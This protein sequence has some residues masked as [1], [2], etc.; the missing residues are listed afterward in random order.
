MPLVMQSR[1]PD[2][3]L[4]ATKMDIGTDVNF[5]NL[6]RV[7]FNYLE[8]LPNVTLHL[9]HELRDLEKLEN[10]QWRLKVKDELNDLKKY[11]DTD[12]VFLGAGGGSLPLLDKS[13]IEEAKGY[14]GFPVSGEWLVCN[15]PEVIEQHAAKV[16]GK[17]SV[18]APPMS[19]PHLDTR[20][21]DGKKELLF[22]P[23]A[24]FSTKFL[25]H[26][27]YFDLPMSIEFD[28]VIPML[29]AG[30]DNI[31]LTKYLILQVSMS[32]E[33]KVEA[34]KEYY[35][36]AKL[37]DWDIKIAGQRVQVIKDDPEKGGVLEFGTELVCS[38]DGSLAALLGASP[39][40]ST[41]VKAML[42]V[43]KK[44]FTNEM[45]TDAWKQQLA[46]MIPIYSNSTDYNKFIFQ[47]RLNNNLLHLDDELKS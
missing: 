31:E 46:T 35:P 22:G 24:G 11:I 8:S 23:F 38:A 12:F 33:E 25:K 30:W 28:N 17:A 18:G 16:Y 42:D 13:D 3:V 27:S 7:L 19:V 36:E 6:T 32:H 10:G 29:Q 14:G 43:L 39:G 15:N 20:M 47:R 44:C 26:G 2:E 45:N 4:A 40:A 5:G 41:S 21:I 34:L 9:N 37:E 1:K